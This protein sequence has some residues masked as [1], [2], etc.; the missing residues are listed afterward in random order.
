ME[1]KFVSEIP[2]GTEEFKTAVAPIE[3]NNESV[4]VVGSSS[5]AIKSTGALSIF[6]PA[7]QQNV[8][9]VNGRCGNVYC[10]DNSQYIPEGGGIE[11]WMSQ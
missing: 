4:L 3:C 9:L 8:A 7:I 5:A 1:I 2:Q 10:S 6:C 11:T